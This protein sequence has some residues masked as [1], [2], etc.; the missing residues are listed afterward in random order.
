MQNPRDQREHMVGFTP[1]MKNVR[2]N[3]VFLRLNG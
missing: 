2:E 1:K 3:I